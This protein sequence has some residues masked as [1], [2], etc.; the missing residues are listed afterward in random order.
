M[1]L[2]HP[3]PGAG[4]AEGE[5]F[6]CA[7]EADV[8]E[9]PLLFK[10]CLHETFF[11]RENALFQANEEAG[12]KF[13]PFGAMQSHEVHFVFIGLFGVG[14]DGLSIEGG[15]RNEVLERFPFSLG[16]GVDALLDVFPFEFAHLFRFHLFFNRFFVVDLVDEPNEGVREGGRF[17]ALGCL[18]HEVEKGRDRFFLPGGPFE[19][20]PEGDLFGAIGLGELVEKG[21]GNA[22]AG[23]IDDPEE[24][25]LIER[26][27]NGPEVGE[28]IF[29]LAAL[30]KFEAA[31][32]FIGDASH[33][34]PLFLPGG[35]EEGRFKGAGEGVGAVEDRHVAPAKPLFMEADEALD[36]G[37]RF[38]EVGRSVENLDEIGLFGGAPE[39]FIVAVFVVADDRIGSF[40]DRGRGAVILLEFDD[41]IGFEIEDV[42]HFSAAPAVDRLIVVADD[43]EVLVFFREEFGEAELGRVRVLVFVDH[44]VAEA[45]L[46]ALEDVGVLFKELQGERDEGVKTDRVIGAQRGL[47][48][49]IEIFRKLIVPGP[50]LI[51]QA[52]VGRLG[53]GGAGGAERGE[54]PFVAE[55]LSSQLLDEPL[56]VLFIIEAEFASIAKPF[57]LSAQDKHAEAV[58]G[59]EGH[60]FGEGGAD[61]GVEAVAHFGCR[62]VG[63]GQA[64]DRL[65]AGS[66]LDQVGNP[67]N[68]DPCFPAASSCEDKDAPLGCLYGSLLGVVEFHRRRWV[69]S[70]AI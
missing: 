30:G 53:E 8:E 35:L 50:L 54:L 58:E 38:V 63:K 34:F 56:D 14:L 5:M 15:V 23:D 25:F 68:D 49:E 24:G 16:E 12:G 62:F 51:R 7:G 2:A 55:S 65:G 37:L 20:V 26:I 48:A 70:S 60:L 33:P 42:F 28:E 3:Q 19:N 66:L 9:A 59:G 32:D 67:V 41:V 47:E 64:E 36:D 11:V 6:L 39:V 17:E 22:A 57:D 21:V 27:G 31:K 18:F 61:Q 52:S 13:E 43:A 44:E 10:P 29:D 46:V 4:H 69:S 1:G 45:V 40:E